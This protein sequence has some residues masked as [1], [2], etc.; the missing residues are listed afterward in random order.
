[1]KKKF[2]I[3]KGQLWLDNICFLPIIAG[4][5]S[6][7]LQVKETLLDTPFDCLA[8]GLPEAYY[9]KTLQGIQLLPY[10]TVVLAK[11][12]DFHHY[13]PIDPCDGMTE[14]IRLAMQDG[15][16]IHFI[17]CEMGE[18]CRQIWKKQKSSTHHGLIFPDD[19]ALEKIGLPAY[20][21]AV[22]TDFV[23]KKNSYYSLQNDIQAKYMASRLQELSLEFG[24]ILFV[25]SIHHLPFIF[26]YYQTEFKSRPKGKSP[27]EISLYTIHPDSLYNILGEVPYFTYLYEKIKGTLY[28][29]EFEKTEGLKKLLLKTRDE[30]QKDFPEEIYR[31]SLQDLQTAL[32]YMKKLSLIKNRLIPDLYEMVVAAKGIMGDGYALKLIETAKFY[33]LFE[34]EPPYPTIKMT[35]KSVRVNKLVFPACRVVPSIAREWKKIKLEKKP[36]KKQKKQWKTCWNPNTVCSWPP[37]DEIIENFCGYVRKRALKIAQISQVRSEEFQ[38]TLKDGIHIR[39]TLRNY[40]LGKIYVKEEPQIHGEVGAIIFIFDDHMDKEKYPYRLTW[41]PE[42]KEESTLAFYATDYKKELVGP[43]VARCFYGGALFI[44]PPQ[45]IPDVWEDRKFIT[46]PSDAER[47]IMAGLYYAEHQYIAVVAKKKPSLFTKNYATLQK[48]RLLFL[49]LSSFSHITL[50]KLR[51]FHVLNGKQVRSWAS[52]FIR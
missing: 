1:M 34:V 15:S 28:F 49:P 5:V 7:A 2:L 40:H 50:Q 42:H 12:R 37:E 17:N 4:K 35:D 14:S 44:Y 21:Q 8:I 25:F 46:A 24:K 29:K 52:Q 6:F 9:T 23:S 32:Q 39:E 27:Q 11:E 38:S 45:F 30:F 13:F 47:L 10:I 19:F 43:G 16:P 22:Y 33:P 36:G 51:Y 18:I 20:V 31:L 48:K 41:L 3:K 26:H